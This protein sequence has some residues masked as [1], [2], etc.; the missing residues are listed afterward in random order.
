MIRCPLVRSQTC[1]RLVLCLLQV[2][3]H[4]CDLP[5]DC[6]YGKYVDQ[7]VKDFVAEMESDYGLVCIGSGGNMPT[8]VQEISL[9]FY[10]YR[11]GTLS[12]ARDLIVQAKTRLIE[13]VN[14]N[15]KIRPYLKNYPFTSEG[16]DISLSFREKNGS[17]YLDDSVALAYSARDNKISYE[18]AEL[19][20]QQ[21]PGFVDLNGTHTPGEWEEEEVL[22]TILEEPFA[23]TM[24][25][26]Q[27]SKKAENNQ[28]KK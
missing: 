15:E 14:M 28:T 18:R 13:K 12:E 27:E 8:N 26:V 3:L 24:R 17:R 16:A 25:I 5:Q 1:V 22:V 6:P 10:V 9:Y 21:T 19:Q 4:G 11:R 20:M 7:I 2:V 23:E